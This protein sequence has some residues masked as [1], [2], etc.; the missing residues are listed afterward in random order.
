M[1]VEDVLA[2]YSLLA[3]TDTNKKLQASLS[4]FAITREGS[5]LVFRSGNPSVE[6]LQLLTIP[7]IKKSVSERIRNEGIFKE[8]AY[9]GLYTFEK[10]ESD[11]V[12]MSENISLV[13]NDTSGQSGGGYTKILIKVFGDAETLFAQ[14][15]S[16]NLV[17]P[18]YYE[19]VPVGDRFRKGEILTPDFAGAFL[20]SERLNPERR[21]LLSGIL[22]T[23]VAGSNGQLRT[24]KNP[25]FT[26]NTISQA[27]T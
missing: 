19:D 24:I 22:H 4:K 6:T 11:P 18:G 12:R 2:T 10:R 1:S 13:S 25:F 9:S 26:E 3:E 23:I 27:F 17:F 5:A 8:E 7:I 16:L 15:D 21:K 14:K 20:N